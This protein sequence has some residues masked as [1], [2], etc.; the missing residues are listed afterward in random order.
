MGAGN[1]RGPRSEVG[2]QKLG[3]E[4]CAAGKDGVAGES[5]GA[6]NGIGEVPDE[7]RGVMTLDVERHID[8]GVDRAG[9]D[10]VQQDNRVAM[11]LPH[12]LEA[13]ITGS[14]C[15][16]KAFFAQLQA[17]RFGGSCIIAGK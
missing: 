1:L 11:L 17:E 5:A 14:E 4:V 9:A 15:D 7:L 6:Q 10:H 16:S 12:A 3:Q 8:G 2:A 13:W